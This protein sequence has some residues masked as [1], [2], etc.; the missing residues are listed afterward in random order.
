[1]NWPEQFYA[2]RA[3]DGCPSCAEGRPDETGFGVRYLAGELCDA[4]LARADIQRGLTISVFRG[5]HGTPTTRGRDGRSRSRTPT[6]RRCRMT[7]SP[8][9]SPHC[10]RPL[11]VPE[12]H[13]EPPREPAPK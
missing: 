5:R 12:R 3:G 7:G 10:A 6:R 1:V 11:A 9:T 2:W 13:H 4:Y 8:R